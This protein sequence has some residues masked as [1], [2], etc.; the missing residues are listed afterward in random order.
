LAGLEP[1]SRKMSVWYLQF[2]DLR[3]HHQSNAIHYTITLFCESTFAEIIYG[4]NNVR[5]LP[6]GKKIKDVH[7]ISIAFIK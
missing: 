5:I 3:V 2:A 6:E 4:L 7:I 1:T